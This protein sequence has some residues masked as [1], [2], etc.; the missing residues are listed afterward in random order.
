MATGYLNSLARA[1]EKDVIALHTYTVSLPRSLIQRH[2]SQH[3]RYPPLRFIMHDATVW[4]SVRFGTREFF[5]IPNPGVTS[6]KACR[7]RGVFP[8]T[9]A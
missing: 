2:V 7:E 3:L 4:Q 5:V 1:R 8:R 6:K 9:T